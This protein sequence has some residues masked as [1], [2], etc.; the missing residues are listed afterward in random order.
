VHVAV[1][2]D[3]VGVSGPNQYSVRPSPFFQTATPP[4]VVEAIDTLS[5]ERVDDADTA[6]LKEV[7]SLTLATTAV[8]PA[9][10]EARGATSP[11]DHTH[12]RG[13]LPR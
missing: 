13:R 9:Q 11:C 8:Q 3:V 7:V 4:I 12:L 6:K 5:V 1:H 2:F 10:L